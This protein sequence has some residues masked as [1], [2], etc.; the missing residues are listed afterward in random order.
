MGLNLY[1]R[2]TD[3]YEN[4]YLFIAAYFLIIMAIVL[5]GILLINTVNLFLNSCF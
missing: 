3:R 5:D 1:K 2:D 4:S